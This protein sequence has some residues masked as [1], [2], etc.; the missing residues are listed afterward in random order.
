MISIY[1]LINPINNEVFYVGASENPETRLMSHNCDTFGNSYKSI[2]INQI[3]SKNKKAEL[4]ILEDN[5]DLS[6]VRQREE[7]YIQLLGVTETQMKT[8]NYPIG[9][10]NDNSP[11]PVVMG[12]LKDIYRIEATRLDRSMHWLMIQ[13]LKEYAKTFKK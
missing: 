2:Q 13:G 7:F 6:N 10:N 3:L 1:A 11:V 9:I 5:C 8:S 4:L 12:D